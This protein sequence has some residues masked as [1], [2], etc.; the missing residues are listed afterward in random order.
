MSRP[1]ILAV[2]DDLTQQKIISLLCERFGF[3]V[4]TVSSCKKAM[5]AFQLTRDIDV[6]LMDGQLR[7]G[8]TGLE[9]ARIL[10]TLE[11]AQGK[12]VPI[13]AMTGMA[14][15]G[16]RERCLAAGMDDYLAK[17]F[18]MEEFHTIVNKWVKTDTQGNVL[19]FPV[20]TPA[21]GAASEYF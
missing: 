13:I 19:R 16:D 9:C 18:T 20:I 21:P 1:L 5:S 7:C 4:V 3:D 17:P 12:H 10:R 11:R 8:V 6:V 14:M 15:P 2:E